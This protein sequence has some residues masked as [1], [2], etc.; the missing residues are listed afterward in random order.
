MRIIGWNIKSPSLTGKWPG[1]T[2]RRGRTVRRLAALRPDIFCGIEMGSINYVNWFRKAM[3]KKGWP[4]GQATGGA[5]WRYIFF[6]LAVFSQVRSGQ[7]VLKGQYRGRD[8]EMT[9]AQLLHVDGRLVLVFCAHLEVLG[10]D[11]IRH[12]QAHSIL[13]HI[14]QIK[15]MLGMSWDDCYLYADVND[16]GGVQRIFQAS[17]LHNLVS[18]TKYDTM[19]RWSRKRRRAKRNQSMDVLMAGDNVHAEKTFSPDCSDSSDHNLVGADV[20]LAS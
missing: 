13:D 10:P 11:S 8:K 9:W 15:N 6:N 1:W 17:R 14:E 7:R 18:A 20:A 19:N 2:V 3:R 16:R 4:M 5:N 12:T